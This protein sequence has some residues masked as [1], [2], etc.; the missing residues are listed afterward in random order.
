MRWQRRRPGLEASEVAARFAGR[1]LLFTVTTGRS[2]TL[3]L[4]RALALHRGVVARHEPRPTFSAALRS[5]LAVPSVAREFWLAHK[6]PRILARPAEVYAETSHLVCKGFL[7]SLVD[8]GVRPELAVLVRPAREVAKSLLAL[9]TIPGRSY[10]GVKYYLSPADSPLLPL[11][12]W[13]RLS[14]YQVCYWYCQEIE[15]RGRAYQARWSSLGVRCARVEFAT[16]IQAGGIETLA[17]SLDLAPLGALARLRARA[18][19]THRWN[20]RAGKKRAVVPDERELEQQETEVLRL[21][22]HARPREGAAR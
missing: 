6:L 9:G 17:A 22:E 10:G 20:E 7:E 18:L 8:L 15:A 11:A 21:L 4:A 19:S 2:G 13:E 1:R 12:G 16:L 3:L 14:D 5:V